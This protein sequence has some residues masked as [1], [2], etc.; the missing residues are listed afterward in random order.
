MVLHC[1]VW[2][3]FSPRKIKSKTKMSFVILFIKLVHQL[4][5]QKE[6]KGWVTAILKENSGI[7]RT[8]LYATSAM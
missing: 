2:D 6:K 3:S 1:K 8:N 5:S 7:Q 4:K